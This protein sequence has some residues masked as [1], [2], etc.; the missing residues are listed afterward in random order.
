MPS[1]AAHSFIGLAI[2]MASFL[3]RVS[4]WRELARKSWN[5]RVALFISVL[6]ANAPDIDYLF[7]VPRGNLN[8][9]HHTVTHTAAWIFAAALAVT[10][11]GWPSRSWRSFLFVL[12]LFASHL[13]ADFFTADMSK[14]YGMMLLW[15]FCARYW[16]SPVPVFASVSKNSLS[17]LL[18]QHN[19]RVMLEEVL[20]VLPLVAAVAIF[21]VKPRASREIA[22]KS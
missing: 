1:P 19:L 5:I 22:T 4:S 10:A 13:V 11:I 17:S 7:G 18:S 15:P 12:A 6:L 2:G 20:I 14:P 3:P 8:F 9:Y 21:K 16:L